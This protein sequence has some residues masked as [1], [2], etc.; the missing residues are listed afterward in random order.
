MHGCCLALYLLINSK[1]ITAALI[2]CRAL[3]SQTASLAEAQK[4]AASAAQA[5]QSADDDF[6]AAQEE[7]GRLTDECSEIDERF[8]AAHA[9][10]KECEATLNAAADASDAAQANLKVVLAF[11]S[12][13]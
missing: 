8:K 9:R 13:C 5:A 12:C 3:A 4:R 6:V 11:M 10:V 2:L 1:V 7:V